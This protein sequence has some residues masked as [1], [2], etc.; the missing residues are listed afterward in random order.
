M[1]MRH[2]LATQ[3]FPQVPHRVRRVVRFWLGAGGPATLRNAYRRIQ[4]KI[5]DYLDAGAELAWLVAPQARTVT[6]YRADGSARLL[7]DL[8]V[9]DGE[10][11]LPGFSVPLT[12]LFGGGDHLGS[13]RGGV[14]P[15]PPTPRAE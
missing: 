10:R 5:R 9:L 3:D 6:V 8:D 7:R 2:F 12:D 11:V 14:A 1:Q 13:A 4:Q 15:A